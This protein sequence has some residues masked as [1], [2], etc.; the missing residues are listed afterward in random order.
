[1]EEGWGAHDAIIS[2]LR[3]A[4]GCLR[5]NRDLRREQR[6]LS[7]SDST[8]GLYGKFTLRFPVNRDWRPKNGEGV[9]VHANA[10]ARA[11]NGTVQPWWAVQ[12]ALLGRAA[13][14]SHSTV[15]SSPPKRD[16]DISEDET[17]HRVNKGSRCLQYCIQ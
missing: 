12:T 6:L 3:V 9:K 2:C 5:P 7:V 4:C 14:S 11:R 15:G 16:K 1:M 10:G 17:C 13:R 8:H